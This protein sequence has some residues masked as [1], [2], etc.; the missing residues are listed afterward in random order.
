MDISSQGLMEAFWQSIDLISSTYDGKTGPLL[1][2]G[3]ATTFDNQPVT[4]I[5]QLRPS[6]SV[7]IVVYPA[8]VDTY[9]PSCRLLAREWI[10]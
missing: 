10:K 4:V 6:P 8:L 3:T 5:F 7:C 1:T 2:I 9:Y